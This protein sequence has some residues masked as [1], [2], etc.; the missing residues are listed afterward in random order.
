MTTMS[1]EI[2]I[3]PLVTEKLTAQMEKGHYAFKVASDANKIEIRNAVEAR[4]PGVQVK[5]VRT[6]VVRGKRRSQFTRRG[7][8]SGRTSAYKKAFVTLKPESEQ[9][10][11]FEEI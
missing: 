10:D 1:K 9:I 4:Y 3:Q 7:R 8:V 5:E 6:M 11:F 2:L